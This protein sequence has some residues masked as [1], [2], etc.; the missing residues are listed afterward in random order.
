VERPVPVSGLGDSGDFNTDLWK[1]EDTDTPVG[2]EVIVSTKAHTA[3]IT[4]VLQT[5]PGRHSH[6]LPCVTVTASPQHGGPT[7]TTTTDRAGMFAFINLPIHGRVQVYRFRFSADGWGTLVLL[8]ALWA[9]Q[10]YQATEWLTHHPQLVDG[11]CYTAACMP[12]GSNCG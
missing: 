7:L 3:A 6:V 4:G 2:M 1:P 9:G 8:D 12:C 11:S 5:P 10:T